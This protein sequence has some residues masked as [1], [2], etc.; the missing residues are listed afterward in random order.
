MFSNCDTRDSSV[1]DETNSDTCLVE[2]N[3]SG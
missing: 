3:L 1:D 2:V